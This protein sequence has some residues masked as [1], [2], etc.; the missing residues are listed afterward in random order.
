LGESSL[1]AHASLTALQEAQHKPAEEDDSEDER[2]AHRENEHEEGQEGI[3]E[4]EGLHGAY[5]LFQHRREKVGQGLD[6]F[7][8]GQSL[9]EVYLVGQFGYYVQVKLCGSGHLLFHRRM[10]F[11][12]FLLT[13]QSNDF[14]CDKTCHKTTGITPFL[15]I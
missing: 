13:M 12:L 9:G 11:S 7:R 8:V 14:F 5:L 1:P 4:T 10:F 6:E 2:D 15:A 3:E